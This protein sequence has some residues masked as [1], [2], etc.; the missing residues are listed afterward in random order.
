MLTEVSEHDPSGGTHGRG[1]LRAR[2]PLTPD[3]WFFAAHF[4]ND[5]CM[6]AVLMFEGCLQAMAFYLA[7][8]GYTIE[9]DG[10]RFEPVPEQTYH[11]RCG[12]QATPANRELTYEVFVIDLIAS[13]EPTLY[14][15]TLCSVDGI[16][17]LH[18]RRMGLRLIPGE[19]APQ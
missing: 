19:V 6:P 3:G 1:Y 9:R 16:Y 13:P 8:L 15:D 18:I 7:A 5:P 17:A 10:W 11:L 14:A 12:R 2:A 4:E